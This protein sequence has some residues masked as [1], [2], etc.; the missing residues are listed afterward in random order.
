MKIL[1]LVLVSILSLTSPA[2]PPRSILQ[3][4][5]FAQ[6]TTRETETEAYA[7]QMQVVSDLA[8]RGIPD[9]YT[10][11]I[12][13]NVWTPCPSKEWLNFYFEIHEKAY[14]PSQPKTTRIV[15]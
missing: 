8:R 9:A 13:S 2:A 11:K 6:L 10:A 15:D 7:R 12:G 5:G 4:N 14:R 3:P 1:S